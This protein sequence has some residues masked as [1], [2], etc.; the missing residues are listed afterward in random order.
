MTE[1]VCLEDTHAG[2]HR[3][4]TPTSPPTTAACALTRITSMVVHVYRALGVLCSWQRPQK[5]PKARQFPHPESWGSEASKGIPTSGGRCWPSCSSRAKMTDRDKEPGSQGPRPVFIYTIYYQLCSLEQIHY[6]SLGP[7]S[8]HTRAL[9]SRV[10]KG[11]SS[12][13]TQ[14]TLKP[15]RNGTAASHSH[16]GSSQVTTRDLL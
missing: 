10:S 14:I 16:R 8:T 4:A 11:P 12:S 1:E 9:E 13:I 2:E 15:L 5:N 6:P 3:D 7:F